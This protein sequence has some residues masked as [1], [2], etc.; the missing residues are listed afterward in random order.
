M[1]DAFHIKLSVDTP[2][3]KAECNTEN[4]DRDAEG[5][6]P[7]KKNLY[8]RYEKSLS[9]CSGEKKNCISFL[10]YWET[11]ETVRL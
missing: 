10:N 7:R 1:M 3:K 5:K 6:N 8:D 4:S 9:V 2:V 11:Q